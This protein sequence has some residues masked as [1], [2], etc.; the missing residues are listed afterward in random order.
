[1]S[2]TRQA[3]RRV[4]WSAKFS[5]T[6]ERV[7]TAALPA[8]AE[9][10]EAAKA[11]LSGDPSTVAKYL[12]G[13]EPTTEEQLWGS[14]ITNPNQFT[15]TS[16]ASAAELVSTL[17]TTANDGET[18]RDVV[19]NVLAMGVDYVSVGLPGGVAAAVGYSAEIEAALKL[20][21]ISNEL[22]AELNLALARGWILTSRAVAGLPTEEV[23]FRLRERWDDDQGEQMIRL[24]GGEQLEFRPGLFAIMGGPGSGKSVILRYIASQLGARAVAFSEPMESVAP[25]WR[26]SSIS[27]P[28]ELASA[29]VEGTVLGDAAI[30]VDSLSRFAFST[31]P[32]WSLVSGGFNPGLMFWL[33]G[34]N[35]LAY[36]RGIPIF[37]TFNPG[38]DDEAQAT[39]LWNLLKGRISGVCRV[40]NRETFLSLDVTIRRG[41]GER[42]T[43]TRKFMRQDESGN[44][45]R[46]EGD[47]TWVFSTPASDVF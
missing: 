33:T 8:L 26:D 18:L 22:R 42:H 30:C 29:L 21:K 24:P 32:G 43:A 12:E 10:L 15:G 4:A 20:K 37:V 23:F 7:A 9:G 44:S 40:V 31:W 34:L 41:S 25:T 28:T 2:K 17:G 27:T 35:N 38:I 36:I 1:M 14:K 3:P 13:A 16:A 47:S 46:S 19:K 39:R 5:P 11:V 45:I 6:G